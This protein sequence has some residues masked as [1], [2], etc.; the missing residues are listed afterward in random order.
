MVAHTVGLAGFTGVAEAGMK[1][2]S[3]TT[4]GGRPDEVRFSWVNTGI[5]NLRGMLVGTCRS[6]D[7]RHV[8]RYLAA[9]EWRFNRRFDLRTNLGR[10][11]R[12]AALTAPAP[13]RVI[14]DVR[15][16]STAEAS[17]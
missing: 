9:Y 17:G 10:L 6:C 13:Y 16:N 8:D 11:T 15:A 3:P 14:A 1:H 5:A 4:G 7:A 12:I 2:V